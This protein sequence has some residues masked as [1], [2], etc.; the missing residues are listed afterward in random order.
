MATTGSLKQLTQ[1]NTLSH[2]RSLSTT[3]NLTAPSIQRFSGMVE[4]LTPPTSLDELDVHQGMVIDIILRLTYN[5]GEVSATHAEE[6]IKLPY[7]IVDDL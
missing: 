7:R 1:S 6:I 4:L 5:E 3:S 2:Q